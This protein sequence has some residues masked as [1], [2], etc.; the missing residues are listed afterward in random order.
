MNNSKHTPGK[1][2]LVLA[3]WG[4][5]APV[6]GY[7]FK[8]GEKEIA[9]FNITTESRIIEDQAIN[10][11]PVLADKH[12]TSEEAETN[13]T[14]IVEMWNNWDEVLKALGMASVALVAKESDMNSPKLVDHI[15][16]LLAR[17]STHKTTQP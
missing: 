7:L 14:R 5:N 2:E 12:F 6:A 17:L 3:K 1:M 16:E 11:F 10:N 9:A 15:L 4:E 8:I 13:A